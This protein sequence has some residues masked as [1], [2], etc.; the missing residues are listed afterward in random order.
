M[1]SAMGLGIFFEKE[2]V[3]QERFKAIKSVARPLNIIVLCYINCKMAILIFPG[4]HMA[5][6]LLCCRALEVQKARLHPR[7]LA[8]E[9]PCESL[10]AIVWQHISSCA[11]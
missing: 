11:L 10:Q 9:S 1:K 4:I 8:P 7:R 3:L 2:Y 6:H 5:P